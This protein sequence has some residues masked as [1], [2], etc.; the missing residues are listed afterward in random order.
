MA[1]KIKWGI[2][3]EKT[4]LT[5]GALVNTPRHCG[6]MI[7]YF[8]RLLAAWQLEK[9]SNEP[10]LLKP[11]NAQNFQKFRNSALSRPDST[12]IKNA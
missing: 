7:L 2:G 9:F 1:R 12:S 10:D 5:Q 8:L 4:K 3:E 11:L 6:E